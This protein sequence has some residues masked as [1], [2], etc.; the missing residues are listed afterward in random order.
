M[1][2]PYGVIAVNPAKHAG[3]NNK[4]AMAFAD[5]LASAEGQKAIADFR[6]NGLQM[7]FPSVR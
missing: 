7:F 6:I 2:N 3:L 1:F 4:G 5:W